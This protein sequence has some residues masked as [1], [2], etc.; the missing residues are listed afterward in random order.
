MHVTDT[1]VNDFKWPRIQRPFLVRNPGVIHGDIA[2]L[3]VVHFTA[4]QE[5]S[6]AFHNIYDF[7]EIM[8]LWR[9]IK[10]AFIDHLTGI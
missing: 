3:Q 4:D 10:G 8:D 1:A 9:G 2:L 5:F 7:A 6:G